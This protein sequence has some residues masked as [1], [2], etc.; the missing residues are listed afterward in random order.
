[1]V[2]WCLISE[3]WKRLHGQEFSELGLGRMS[4]AGDGFHQGVNRVAGHAW[5]LQ[6]G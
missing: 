4:P 3:I 6:A 2:L 1:M 5:G